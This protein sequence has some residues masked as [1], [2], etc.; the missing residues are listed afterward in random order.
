LRRPFLAAAFAALALAF[1]ASATAETVVSLTFDDG[2]ANQLNAAPILAEHGMS[3]TF[4]INSNSIGT[5]GRLSWAQLD[6]LNA[7][8]HEIAGHTLDHVDLTTVTET[9]ARRQVCEDR[10][11]LINHGFVVPNFA[12]PFGEFNSAAKTVVQECGYSSGRGAFGL[13]NITATTDT[14]P[15]AER[16][17]PLDRYGIRTPCCINSTITAGM[18]Q[19]YITQA[20]NGGGGWVPLVLHRIC[21]ACGDAEAPSMSPATLEALLDW[22]QPRASQGTVV[23]TVGQVISGDSQAPASAIACDGAVCSSGWYGD[24][25]SV[26]LAAAD[27]GS[28]V[29]VIRYTLDGSEPTASS[30]AYGGPFSVSATTTV[31]F[32]AWDNAGNVET[33]QSQVIQIDTTT[34]LSSISCDGTACSS[35]AYTAPVTVALSATDAGSGVAVIRYTLDGSEPTASSAAYGGPFSVSATTTVKFR[36][37]D[38]AGNVE[39]TQ[40]QLVQ[41]AIAPPD[42]EAPTSSISCDLAPCSS[43]W[44]SDPVSVSLAAADGGSG[45]AVIRYTLDGSE[46]TASSAAYGGPFS[47]SATTTVKF[48]AWDNAGNVEATKS[49]L[50]QVDLAGPTVAITSPAGNATVRGTVKV[51]A[52]A[53][54]APSGVVQVSFYADGV[55]LG[56]KASAPYSV[57]WNTKKVSPGQHVLT[58]VARD[59]AGNESVSAP[60]QVNVAR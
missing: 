46:P 12:Y 49:Q 10:A 55:L 52:A 35:A 2:W 14:R 60:V 40:S 54:D 15:H 31:K 32:R 4:Y 48:R 56:T 13:R 7:A 25:V 36:A 20:E 28:G 51:T 43:G 59:A 58:A 3:G 33:T 38:N 5:S 17:P 45:V 39:A 19:N 11:N 41:V 21:D 6:A 22:L 24:S 47:V 34:P 1:P 42:T 8:G 37:W 53:T 26:S 23:R 27:G 44:Y 18:L 57:S 16:I 9:E 30:A 50:I 29:G